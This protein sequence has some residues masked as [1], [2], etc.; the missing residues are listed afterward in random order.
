MFIKPQY[1]HIG[2]KERM[3]VSR[4]RKVELETG[5]DASLQVVTA[6]AI[7]ESAVTAADIEASS[8]K[9][10]KEAKKPLYLKRI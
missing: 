2:V 9:R 10:K 3:K 4:T 5:T 6:N 8:E 7:E 1:A